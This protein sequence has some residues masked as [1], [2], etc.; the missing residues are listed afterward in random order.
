MKVTHSKIS[1]RRIQ[2]LSTRQFVLLIARTSHEDIVVNVWIQWFEQSPEVGFSD[3]HQSHDYTR[4]IYSYSHSVLARR[5]VSIRSCSSDCEQP[6]STVTLL[7]DVC[8]IVTL[9]VHEKRREC[10]A[11][12]FASRN[13]SW[14]RLSVEYIVV[15]PATMTYCVIYGLLPTNAKQMATPVTINCHYYNTL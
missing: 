7:T 3:W 12:L 14:R 2:W 9:W 13:L 5:S 1:A 10:S 4:L 6:V 15:H 11:Y 8:T